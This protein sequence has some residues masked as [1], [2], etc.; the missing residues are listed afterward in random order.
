MTRSEH[1]QQDQQCDRTA[2]A[3]AGDEA[4]FAGDDV[5]QAGAGLAADG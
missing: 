1:R 4:V 5:R 2:D 3:L